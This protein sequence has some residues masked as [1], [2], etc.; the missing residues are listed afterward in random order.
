MILLVAIVTIS[1]LLFG[2]LRVERLEREK[3][4]KYN[5]KLIADNVILQ[6]EHLKFQLQPHTLRNMV[7]TIHA[8]AKNLYRGSE[9]LAGTLDYV[10]YQVNKH[11]V[12]V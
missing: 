8:A 12:S 10:L 11:L 1:I 7:A 2:K 6:A 5:R 3:L 4:A 9:A